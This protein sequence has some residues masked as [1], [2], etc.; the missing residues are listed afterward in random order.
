MPNISINI[1]LVIQKR[2]YD[3]VI[4]FST[5]DKKK[6]KKASEKIV[7]FGYL[8]IEES[9]QILNINPKTLPELRVFTSGWKK[10]IPT[11]VM[12]QILSIVEKVYE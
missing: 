5:P 3:Y 12:E 9:Y 8:N 11:E 10:L 2:T 7:A 4:K 1:K 6:F